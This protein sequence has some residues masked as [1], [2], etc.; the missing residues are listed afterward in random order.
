MK[1]IV[2]LGICLLIMC[3]V[4]CKKKKEDPVPVPY[5]SFKVNGV[6]KNYTV[7]SKFSKDLCSTSTFC[8]RFSSNETSNAAQIKFGIPGDPIVGYVY[9]SGEYRFSCFYLDDAGV[10]YDF[11]TAPFTLVFTL[12]EGQGGWAKG[13]FSGW[14]KSAS[15]DSIEIKDGYFQNMI[16][17]IG[18]K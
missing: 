13:N 1:K 14:M 6:Q 9:Q 8:C 16:W 3:A 10:R 5:T 12:W 11:T 7:Y 15:N 4:S 17:T 18:T 2:I